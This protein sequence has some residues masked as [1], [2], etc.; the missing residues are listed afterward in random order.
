MRHI[1]V[2]FLFLFIFFRCKKEVNTP[3]N[4][5][6]QQFNIY[7]TTV[8]DENG[9]TVWQVNANVPPVSKDRRY[10]VKWTLA[11]DVKYQNTLLIPKNVRSVKQPTGIPTN[12]AYL[13]VYKIEY[14]L[15]Q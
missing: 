4:P 8:K 6:E 7:M 11:E 5:Q 15:V 9:F 10:D 1:T 13:T 12:D 2:I 3:G 14:C